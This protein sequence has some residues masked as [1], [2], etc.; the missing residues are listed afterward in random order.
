[1]DAITYPYNF[2]ELA[3]NFTSIRKELKSCVHPHKS[4]KVAFLGGVTTAH[5]KNYL[6]LFLLKRGL[7]SEFYECPYNQFFKE[8]VDGSEELQKFAPDFVIIYTGSHN[9]EQF[10]GAEVDALKAV[11]A[12]VQKQTKA[13]II[14]NNFEYPNLRPLGNL[15]ATLPEGRV[16]QIREINQKLAEAIRGQSGV[17]LHDMNYL[18]SLVGL[19]HWHDSDFWYLYKYASSLKSFPF[20]AESLSAIIASSQGLSKKLLAL[21]A[22]NTLWGGT[23]AEDG[24]DNIS[25]GAE[26]AEGQSFLNFQN[27]CNALKSRGVILG[28]ISKNDP[29]QAEVGLQKAQ[30]RL[31]PSDFSA[32]QVNWERKDIN[33]EKMT[34]QLNIGRDAVVFIDDNP[35]ES[36]LMRTS[37]PEVSSPNMSK[38]TN[39]FEVVIDRNY[40]FEP[41]MLSDEDKRRSELYSSEQKRVE[42]QNQFVNYGDFLSN[43]KMSVE[44]FR[45]TTAEHPR[46]VQLINKTN[47]FN[48]TG[49]KFNEAEFVQYC[50]QEHSIVLAAN[51][52]DKFGDHGL[53]TLVMGHLVN[54][55]FKIDLWVMSCRVIGKELERMLLDQLV[56]RVK[57]AGAKTIAAEYT[58]SAKN[59]L[60]RNLLPS[61]GFR[62]GM[63]SVEGYKDQGVYIKVINITEGQHAG[64]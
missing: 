33:L 61:L 50:S 57:Q 31:K 13:V 29:G 5:I 37:C 27:Y 58:P 41:V 44:V 14:Q 8:A 20:I 53:V 23:I 18:A 1:M 43:L 15:E 35:A 10:N 2:D 3:Q 22:D 16:H 34:K 25:I 63:L 36:E 38:F 52:K 64:I 59:E 45:P 47:Q 19:E 30:S 21:D 11:W 49:R 12:G 9:I 32:L 26:T 39:R 28:L 60:V 46:L 62:N 55:T 56:Y 51:L 17:L 6:E 7:A 40:F 4:I 48:L 54:D 42:E 24:L